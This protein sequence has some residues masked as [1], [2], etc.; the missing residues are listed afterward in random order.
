MAKEK[1]PTAIR[2]KGYTNRR[3]VEGVTIS[4]TPEGASKIAAGD[5]EVMTKLRKALRAEGYGA[6]KEAAKE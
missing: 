4:T 5:K 6:K 2:V 1:D 3:N